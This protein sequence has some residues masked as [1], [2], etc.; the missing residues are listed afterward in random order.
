MTVEEVVRDP[1]T[2]VATS[3]PYAFERVPALDGIRALAIAAVLLFHNYLYSSKA[4]P[5]G[6]LGVDVFFVLSG[7]LITTLLL[8]EHSR[9]H[10]IDFRRFWS[11]RA[12]R[13]LP[14]L[15]VLLLG[16]AV[17]ARFAFSAVTASQM[18]GDGV[19]S[20]LYFENWRAAAGA[21]T[22]LGHTWSLSIEEQWYLVWPLL[23]AAL[24]VFARERRRI[25][26]VFVGV[27]ALGS[28]IE[29]AVLFSGTGSRAYNGTDTRAQALLVG[30]ALAA[31]LVWRPRVHSRLLQLGA[32][33]AVALLAVSVI[34]VHNDDAWLYRGG[35]LLVAIASALL[36]AAAVR[37]P[38][39]ALGRVLGAPPLV[40]IGLVS[41]GLYL[42]H[43]PIYV[44][45]SP[46]RTQLR[47]VAL[48]IL[49][50]TVTA[51][52][53]IASYHLIE[54]PFRR[55]LRLDRKRVVGLALGGVVALGAVIVATPHAVP[56]P[57][58]ITSYALTL[59][60]RTTPK[61][62]QRVLVVGDSSAF[63]FAMRTGKI[64]DGD[65]IRGAVYAKD[66][67]DLFTGKPVAT[68]QASLANPPGCGHLLRNIAIATHAYAP[69]VSVLM[70]G[71]SEARDRST[72]TETL[73]FGSPE[74]RAHI[75]ADIDRART[76][77]TST[78][79]RF[80]LLPVQ[81]DPSAP[82]SAARVRW[83]NQRLDEYAREH[84]PTLYIQSE[85]IGRCANPA[86]DAAQ[87]WQQLAAALR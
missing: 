25:L 19:G 86:P 26:V 28:A 36:I 82:V 75:V 10:R 3:T 35:F 32:W 87:T 43:W 61:G 20:L 62:E 5:G 47:G 21:P 78:G 16:E 12:S 33:V 23:L 22:V 30:A 17:L 39:A 41:Y 13:L 73:L 56:A 68:S 54:K 46:D 67:C 69:A 9:A 40:A 76:E 11:R 80:V 55:G 37:S 29:C 49:R 57:I 15:F 81:C 58:D 31:M 83:L 18:R 72:G 66:G 2:V 42:Y 60:A 52:V 70:I 4:W 50:L 8:Q 79:A 74:F 1:S 77:L 38:T 85:D 6:F 53:A 44:W 63:D 14:A 27:L 45:L 24:L 48:L 84:R 34:A 64:F 51:A 59:A 7:F 71:T 65:S